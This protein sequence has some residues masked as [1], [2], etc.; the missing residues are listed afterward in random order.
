MPTKIKAHTNEPGYD[1][2]PITV[3]FVSLR[4]C[5]FQTQ[6]IVDY[7]AVMT[8]N[9]DLMNTSLPF[10]NLCNLKNMGFSQMILYDSRDT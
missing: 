2:T 7:E 10:Q 6:D 9:V 8:R 3:H 1:S 4:S 5:I